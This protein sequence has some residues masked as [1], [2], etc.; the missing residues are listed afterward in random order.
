[1]NKTSTLFIIALIVL[2][3]YS[4]FIEPSALTIVKYE[5]T[6]P[7]YDGIKIAYLSDF[8]F[9]QKENKRLLKILKATIAQEPDI[10]LLGGDYSKSGKKKNLMIRKMALRL[11]K[12]SAKV[13]AVMGENDI[14]VPGIVEDLKK[15]GIT[16][17]KNT[18]ARARVKGKYFDII[19]I[20]DITTNPDVPSAFNRTMDRRI[21]F[22]HN[23][24]VY[25]SILDDADLILAGHT[26]GGQ[27]ILP[28]TPPLFVPSKYGAQ[29]A[30][31]YTK[32]NKNIMII[33]RGLGTGMLPVRFRCKPEILIVEF[34]KKTDHGG[35]YDVKVLNADVPKRKKSKS[36]KTYK[37]SKIKIK[38]EIV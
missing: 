21:V 30:G 29:F 33:S 28:F 37:S 3:F 34:V 7:Y 23:P 24:D 14:Q 9:K 26:M 5:I 27:F 25:Y 1:M 6:N 16:V 12:T 36:K 13:Y 31:G 38:K 8:N 19:G 20:G 17:L 10:I 18:S 2:L 11:K 22:T 32:Q 15:G 35:F 4:V